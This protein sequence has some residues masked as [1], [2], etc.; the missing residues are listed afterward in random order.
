MP[1]VS[2]DDIGTYANNLSEFLSAKRSVIKKVYEKAQEL[3]EEDTPAFSSSL[4]LC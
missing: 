4:R 3:G 2:R 1:L